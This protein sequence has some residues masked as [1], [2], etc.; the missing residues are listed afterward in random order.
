[1]PFAA[2][3]A[4]MLISMVCWG[5]WTNASRLARQGRLEFFH[6]DFSW[7]VFAVAVAAGA[8]GLLDSLGRA[9]GAAIGSALLGGMA[10]NAGNLVLVVGIARVGMT[11]ASPVSVGL[12][13]VLSTSLSYLVQPRG[14]AAL[15]AAGVALILCAA[16]ANALA[17]RLAF[18]P[19]GG[20]RRGGLGLCVAAGLLFSAAAPLATHA[21]AAAEPL[22]PLAAAALYA[23]GGLLA[24]LL[25]L[26]WLA[27][28]PVEGGP[29]TFAAYS[30]SSRRNHLAGL[31]GGAIWGTGM[32]LCFVAGGAAGMALAGAVGQ[33]NPLVAAVWGIFVWREFHG[34]SR[35]AW[36]A[37]ALAIALYVAGLLV[38]AASS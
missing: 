22:S 6:A 29:Y 27:R 4:L 17:Y 24:G 14:N 37:L 8:A 26:A 28:R 12:A 20:R 21:L 38:L 32:T 31:A 15:L 34:A 18:P 7:G 13:L 10:V 16:M 5:S 2:A 11:V 35:R 30:A 3:L 9:S 25:L 36:Q 19:Q 23:S 33:A 1:M